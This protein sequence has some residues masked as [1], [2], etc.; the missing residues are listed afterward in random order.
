MATSM[1]IKWNHNEIPENIV[2]VIVIFKFM[3]KNA[4]LIHAKITNMEV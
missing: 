4:R 3:L 2:F 1:L